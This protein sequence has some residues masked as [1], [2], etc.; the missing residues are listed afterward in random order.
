MRKAPLVLLALAGAGP[1]VTL[2]SCKEKAAIGPAP[3]AT[4]AGAASVSPSGVSSSAAPVLA[5]AASAS[6]SGGPA[7]ETVDCAG[8]LGAATARLDLA[9]MKHTRCKTDGDCVTVRGGACVAACDEAIAVTGAA[10]YEQARKRA[11]PLC[12][13]FFRTDCIHKHPI[14][15]PTCPMMKARCMASTC[16]ASPM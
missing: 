14:P 5:P 10:E 2:A 8:L 16:M 6:P 7:S 11:Q 4:E 13:I 12:D 1:A 15:V 3:S 9:R